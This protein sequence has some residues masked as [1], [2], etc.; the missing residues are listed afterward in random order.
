M[1]DTDETKETTAPPAT[2][3]DLKDALAGMRTLLQRTGA[4]FAAGAA[5]ILA[6]LGYA[7]IHDLTPLPHDYWWLIALVALIGASLAL[8]GAALFAGRFFAAQRRILLASEREYCSDLNAEEET[9]RRQLYDDAARENGGSSLRAVELRG[10]R[11]ERIASQLS[12]TD[13]RR[14]ALEAEAERLKGAVRQG[15]LNTAVS[16]L[17]RRSTRAFK[18][19]TTVITV[20][21]FVAGVLLLFGAADYS[22]GQRDLV[23][24]RKDCL[25]VQKQG[26]PDACNPVLGGPITVPPADQTATFT[27]AKQCTA[28]VL[29]ANG[30][31]PDPAVQAAVVSACASL[32]GGGSGDG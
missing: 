30:L 17:E 23:D 6:G 13:P 19:W 11:L 32:A 8:A 9:L 21:M 14:A 26:D 27:A 1:A 22:K 24:A 4:G 7:R 15:M 25:A 3:D 20:S 5:A 31:S 18:S 2:T 28:T 12:G 10:Q 29:G 16:I